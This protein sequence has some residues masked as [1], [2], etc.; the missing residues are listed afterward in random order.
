M[1][2]KQYQGLG[3]A[4]GYCVA[5]AIGDVLIN[6]FSVD[7]STFALT[8]FV[9]LVTLLTF[10]LVSLIK[11]GISWLSSIPGN[12]WP[13]IMLNIMTMLGWMGAFISLKYLTPSVSASIYMLS[14]PFF[15]VLLE[16]KYRIPAKYT[17]LVIAIFSTNILLSL[18]EINKDGLDADFIIGLI[19]T[20]VGA[21]GAAASMINTKLLINNGF[22]AIQ[23]LAVRFFLV[24]IVSF[25]LTNM[26]EIN[27]L[28]EYTRILYLLGFSAIV[29]I[30]PVFLITKAI[31]YLPVTRVAIIASSIPFLTYLVQFILKSEEFDSI[32]IMLTL[33]ASI[34]L[35][36]KEFRVQNVKK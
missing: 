16:N 25:F 24:V 9:F 26:I 21:Y 35:M 4:I 10:A 31:E 23:S 7:N 15:T 18:F 3:F 29:L 1:E 27:Q 17:I 30:A 20:I 34:V 8:L 32:N 12:I 14:V 33:A 13:I 36:Y 11:H 6:I 19:A 22:S 5:I 2:N 28:F